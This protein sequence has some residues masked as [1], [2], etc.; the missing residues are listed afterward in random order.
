MSRIGCIVLTLHTSARRKDSTFYSVCRCL[1]VL[2]ALPRRPGHQYMI[3]NHHKVNWNFFPRST[4]IF[5]TFRMSNMMSHEKRWK[6]CSLI[7]ILK[8]ACWNYVGLTSNCIHWTQQW[9]EFHS[10]NEI[11]YGLATDKI[12]KGFLHP[13]QAKWSIYWYLLIS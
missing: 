3:K 5:L 2:C 8:T 1:H 12:G 9:S 6:L 13:L 11:V 7:T 10:L 4:C